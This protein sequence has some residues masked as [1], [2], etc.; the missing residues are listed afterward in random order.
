MKTKLLFT[1]QNST[2]LFGLLL[3]CLCF[4]YGFGQQVIGQFPEIDG[5]YEAQ[6]TGT[7]TNAGSA[8]ADVPQ[9]SWTV[10]S[11]SRAVVREINDDASLARSGTFSSSLQLLASAGDNLRLQSISS[12]SPAFQ[13]ATEYTIQFFYK[14]DVNPGDDLDPGIYLNNTSSGNTTN[15]T[16][17]ST[18]AAGVYTKA[19]GT[20]TTGDNFNASNWA[21]VRIAGSNE[22]LL[23][24][25]DFVV[26][27]GAYDDTVPNDATDGTYANNAGTATVGWT[28]PGDGVD[29]GGY[30]VVRYTS[31]PNADNDPNQN[32]IYT[33]GN[34]TTNGTGG[35][36]GTVA[37]IGTATTFDE[38]YVAGTFYKV[39]AVDKAFNYSDELVISDANL[40][41]SENQLSGLKLYPNPAND[42]ISI[43]SNNALITSVEIFNILGKSVYSQNGL[44]DNTLDIS[45]LSNGMYLLKITSDK[46]SITKKIIKD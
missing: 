29:G 18:F 39:Y 45:A 22:T 42:F 10:S 33:V 9:T 31:A 44:T 17:A 37:Y 13:T 40:G 16:D 21:V 34:T 7:M 46:G 5:G 25:D 2:K 1:K 28:A 26:Y 23:A 15:K 41:V 32:G 24:F 27:T 4:N 8:E 11:S 38:P 30:V 12:T 20:V 35:L 19:Y 36:T 14:A 43:E 6:P 3:C